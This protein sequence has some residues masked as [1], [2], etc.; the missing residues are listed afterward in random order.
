MLNNVVFMN[1][2]WKEGGT[3]ERKEGRK[4]I[5]FL[6]ECFCFIFFN[7]YVDWK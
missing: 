6:E 5:V 7:L 3:E 4:K 2:R 1:E